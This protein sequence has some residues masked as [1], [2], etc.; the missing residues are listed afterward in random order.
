MDAL[1]LVIRKNFV[2]TYFTSEVITF[3]RITYFLSTNYTHIGSYE[4]KFYKHGDIK[5]LPNTKKHW[6]KI[7]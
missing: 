1:F 2:D 7:A 3:G 4:E 5:I 6:Y